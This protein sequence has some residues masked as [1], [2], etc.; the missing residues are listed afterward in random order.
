MAAGGVSGASSA[1]QVAQDAYREGM[2]SVKKLL[3]PAVCGDSPEGLEMR[4]RLLWNF[5]QFIMPK[6]RGFWRSECTKWIAEKGVA[7]AVGV[8]DP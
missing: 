7:W 3:C 8:F 4:R 6:F 1:L 5:S 2:S